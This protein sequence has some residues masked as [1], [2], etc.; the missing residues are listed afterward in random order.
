MTP[1][2]IPALL[3]VLKHSKTLQSHQLVLLRLA[4]HAN[5]QGVA[6]PSVATLMG[7]TGY[8]RKWIEQVLEALVTVGELT[9][10]KVGRSYRYRLFTYDAKTDR[11]TCVLT[12]HIPEA[13]GQL[14]PRYGQLLPGY[15]QSSAANRSYHKGNS[16]EPVGEPVYEPQVID[17]EEDWKRRYDALYAPD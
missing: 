14:V 2:S 4:D 15:G 6:W 8:K 12:D 5:L 13:H 9:R 7:E 17:E 1:M 16:T 11:C 3:H 10:E